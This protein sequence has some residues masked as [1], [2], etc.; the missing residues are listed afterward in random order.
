MK[1]TSGIDLT[2]ARRAAFRRLA[3]H[4]PGIDREAYDAFGRDWREP[5]IGLGPRDARVCIFGRDPGRTEVEH[6]QPF[7]GK[8][9]QLVRAAL[10]RHGHGADAVVPDFAASV[11]AGREVF[12]LNTVP[13]KPV[14]NRAWSMAVKRRFQPLMAELLLD[15]WQGRGGERTVIALGREAFFWFGIAQAAHVG[16]AL[17]AFWAQGDA[18][19]R[20]TLRIDY[21]A[22]G[23]THA[24]TLA[25]LPHPSPA[26]A[27]WFARFAGLMDE[28]LRSLS[29]S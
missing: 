29:N 8:G 18:R 26:N 11:A 7:V 19:Y 21:R 22:A 16:A 9:G 2:P 20:R 23:A 1:P 14:G 24:I 10:Y 15:M 25:P 13:Y 28:R 27:V 12:W 4:T 6:A 17:D 3:E 5:I